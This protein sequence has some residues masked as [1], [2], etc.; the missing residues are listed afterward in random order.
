V[1]GAHLVHFKLHVNKLKNKKEGAGNS[2]AMTEMQQCN[3]AYDG[4]ARCCLRTPRSPSSS[5]VRGRARGHTAVL[6]E[7]GRAAV[8]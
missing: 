3:A 4:G 8:R 6:R 5:L 1:R 7:K 2:A